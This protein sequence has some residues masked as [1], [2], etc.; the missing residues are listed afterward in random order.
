MK[1]ES[2][3]EIAEDRIFTGNGEVGLVGL[4]GRDG[5]FPVLSFKKVH[6][7]CFVGDGWPQDLAGS[8]S[9]S[10]RDGEIQLLQPHL[11]AESLSAGAETSGRCVVD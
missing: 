6:T 4:V 1:I 9:V 7:Y 10:S 8:N 11:Y 2:K 3:P 5:N